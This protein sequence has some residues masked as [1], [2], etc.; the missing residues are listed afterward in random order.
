[1]Y[2]VVRSKCFPFFSQSHVVCYFNL[3]SHRSYSKLTYHIQHVGII[4]ITLIF[5][6]NK[7]PSPPAIN[8]EHVVEGGSYNYVPT[9]SSCLSFSS[10]SHVVCYFYLFSPQSSHDMITRMQVSLSMA[11]F[12]PNTCGYPPPSLIPPS[13]KGR[14]LQSACI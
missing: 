7:P 13:P 3:F 12:C 2:L 8:G 1:M 10:K 11:V 9:R 4:A 6:T 5:C 14:T